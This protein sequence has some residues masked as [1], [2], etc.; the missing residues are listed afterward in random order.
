VEEYQ[1]ELFQ[2]LSLHVK[3]NDLSGR[4]NLA[5]AIWYL[6]ARVKDSFLITLMNP[7]EMALLLRGLPK[8]TVAG[9]HQLDHSATKALLMALGIPVASVKIP[10]F[11]TALRVLALAFMH[12]EAAGAEHFEEAIQMLIRGLVL[13]E[14]KEMN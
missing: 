12:R 14:V 2:G 7:E 9:H 4:E 10:L 5:E 6:F 3:E 13:E 1:K 11:S 8:E